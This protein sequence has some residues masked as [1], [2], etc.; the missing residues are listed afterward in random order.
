[1]NLDQLRRP[2]DLGGGLVLGKNHG[3]RLTHYLES[4]QPFNQNRAVFQQDKITQE[5][6]M[7]LN[8]EESVHTQLSS[9]GM[10]S[11]AAFVHSLGMENA[12]N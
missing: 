1:M 10:W 6:V 3:S 11:L 12:N 9:D 7:K 2:S 5:Q 4:N 8:Q